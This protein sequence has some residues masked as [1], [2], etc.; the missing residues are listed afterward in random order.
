MYLRKRIL[1]DPAA[2][3]PAGATV[4][5]DADPSTK[6]TTDSSP[7]V[8][9]ED[10]TKIELPEGVTPRQ[11]TKD[12]DFQEDLHDDF[13]KVL[14]GGTPKSSPKERADEVKEL[15]KKAKEAR[16]QEKNLTTKVKPTEPAKPQSD[17]N[18]RDYSD[19]P[20]EVKPLFQ[21]MSNDAFARLKPMFLEH[22]A[23]KDL[24]ESQKRDLEAAR[25]G[26][27]NIPENWYDNPNAFTLLP[28]A[29]T[30]EADF[31]TANAIERHWNEQLMK[32][33]SGEDW[34]DLDFDPKTGR[35]VKGAPQPANTAAKVSVLG[36]WQM[37]KD[38]VKDV[39]ASYIKLRDSFK[40]RHTTIVNSFNERVDHYLPMFKDKEHAFTKQ[41][42]PAL[43]LFPKAYQ[44][45]PVTVACAKLMIVNQSL[46]QYV[47]QLETEKSKTV[48]KSADI[49]KA[50]P[51]S[52]DLG[53]GTMAARPA[54]IT[55]DDFARE[56][57]SL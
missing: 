55:M 57:V 7:S 54:D 4:T 56:G 15:D 46:M 32:I 13:E 17:V 52:A 3:E 16:A 48:A 2:T 43:D 18:A 19:L 5:P 1:L 35:L 11:P 22:R 36:N 6:V 23:Q 12:D 47:K 28:E 40:E 29:Q 49:K 30:L 14:D 10:G 41:L 42:A 26:Q 9:L 20:D 38:Q 37:A 27:V 21:K 50:G 39:Q 53:T 34:Q 44:N 45:H 25:K 51:T 33:E 8:R 31:A 24:I